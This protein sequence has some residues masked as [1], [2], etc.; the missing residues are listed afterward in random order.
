MRNVFN[1][2][3]I[4]GF[5][6]L[7]GCTVQEKFWG[8]VAPVFISEEA[9]Q[10]I[11]STKVIVSLDQDE[12]LGIPIM[13]QRTSHQYSGVI[14]KLAESATVRFGDDLSEEQRRLLRGIDMVAFRFDTAVKFREAAQSSLSSIAWLNVSSV[15]H[16]HDIP[17]A[18]IE[19]IVQTQDED[20][21]MLIDNRYLMAIDFSSITVFSYVSLYAHERTLVKMA[22]DAKPYED[23]PTLYKNLFLYE[24]RYDGN[25]T[26]AGDALKGW[27]KNEGEMVQRAITESITDLTKQIIDDLSFTTLKK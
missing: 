24:F 3:F 6:L 2:L 27:N 1:I 12:R 16:Q 25:Y 4:A 19:R 18:E 13:G 14:G 9:K 7:S 20:V 23:P 26:N 22:K 21:L 15:V 17:L 10:R 11:K 8:K 5:I